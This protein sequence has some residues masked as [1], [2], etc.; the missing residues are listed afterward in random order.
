[1]YL[2]KEEEEMYKGEQGPAREWAMKVLTKLG[3]ALGAERL[4]KIS[5]AEAGFPNFYSNLVPEEV[6]KDIWRRG[7]GVPCCSFHIEADITKISKDDYEKLMAFEKVAKDLN[8]FLIGTCAPYAVGWCPLKG[9]HVAY[10]ESSIVA[11]M[12]SV[13]GVR[14]HTNTFPSLL[15]SAITGRTPYWGFHTDEGRLGKLLV[16]VEAELSDP[17]DYYALG[18]YIGWIAGIRVPVFKGVFRNVGVEHL[19]GLGAALAVSGGVGLYHVVGITPEAP[20]LEIAFGGKKPEETVT[21]G[22]QEIREAYDM[23]CTWGSE[24]VDCVILG[25]PHCTLSELWKVHNLLK[26]KKIHK[27]VILWVLVPSPLRNVAERM[28]L[29]QTINATGG[30]IGFGACWE[31]P[32]SEAYLGFDSDQSPK[33]VATNSAKCAHYVK[34]AVRPGFPMVHVWFGSMEKCLKTALTGKWSG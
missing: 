12:N 8:V 16:K 9:A 20:T 17:A 18:Y 23:L 29:T 15:A 6:I 21:V 31:F 10:G 32:T 30:R 1:L 19:K 3:D 22:K 26:G 11:Y 33:V 4:I 25:C 27:D 24:K 34:G 5:N 14:T 13:L 7:Y 28:G 2:T